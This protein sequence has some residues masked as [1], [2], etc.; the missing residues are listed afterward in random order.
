MFDYEKIEEYKDIIEKYGIIQI[1][2]KNNVF[3]SYQTS[4]F[5]FLHKKSTGLEE[6]SDM[7]WAKFKQNVKEYVDNP[8]TYLK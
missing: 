4:I 8:R 1:E 3:F 2:F 5:F 6:I 7:N